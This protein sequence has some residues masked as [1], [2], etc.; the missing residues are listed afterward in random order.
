M[1]E[2]TVKDGEGGNFHEYWKQQFRPGTGAFHPSGDRAQRN[3]IV[4]CLRR[5]P[6]RG[7]IEGLFTYHGS[8][9]I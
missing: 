2:G 3:W 7:S 8:M 1:I 9:W 4:R 6:H 5:A